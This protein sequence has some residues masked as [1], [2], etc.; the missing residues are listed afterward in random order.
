[1]PEIECIRSVRTSEVGRLISISGTIT[2]TAEVR[3]ELFYGHFICRKCGFVDPA[4]EQQFQYTEPVLCRNPQCKAN[5]DFQLA[6]DK[7]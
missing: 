6:L 1:M 7:R 4:V 5:N 2:R 3:P